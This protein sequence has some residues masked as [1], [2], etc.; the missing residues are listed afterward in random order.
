MNDPFKASA[1][2]LEDAFFAKR[3]A[4]KLAALRAKLAKEA[5]VAELAAAIGIEDPGILEQLHALDIGSD[6]LAALALVPLV[7]VA[8]ADG[9]L[10]DKERAAILQAAQEEGAK[11]GGPAMELLETW[12]TARPGPDLRAA[13]FEYV[14]AFCARLSPE[15]R[16]ALQED[17]LSR[18]R[19]VAEATGGF[20]GF[21]RRVS[22][23]EQQ[24]LDDLL[25][26]FA[27]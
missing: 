26:A 23:S 12:L 22:P 1:K 20:L 4:E 11:A 18:T 14:R 3:D 24:V 8:W 6:T 16:A 19:R 10:D 27:E 9:E 17:L 21:G 15:S 2:A 7:E 13:W 25:G 5:E